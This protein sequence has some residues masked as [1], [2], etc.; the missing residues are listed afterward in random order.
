MAVS[1]L[2][3]L[4][5]QCHTGVGS[6]QTLKT[7]PPTYP[8]LREESARLVIYLPKTMAFLAGLVWD[9]MVTVHAGLEDGTQQL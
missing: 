6:M 2:T 7:T 8:L 4:Q 1:R 5:G 3:P 9:R